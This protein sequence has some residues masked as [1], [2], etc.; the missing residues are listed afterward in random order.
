MIRTSPLAIGLAVL[1][2]GCVNEAADLGQPVPLALT[3]VVRQVVVP[4]GPSRGGRL[5]TAALRRGVD[6]LAA[7]VPGA[8]RAEI[9]ADSPGTA[10]T[11]R[12]SLI[13]LGLD[14]ARITSVASARARRGPEVVLSRTTAIPADCRAAVAPTFGHDPLPSLMNVAHC[15]QANDLAAM[16][17]D[18][19]DLVAPPKLGQADGAYLADGVG[20]WR[21][22]RQLSL[23]GVGPAPSAAVGGGGGPPAPSPGV[24][25]SGNLAPPSVKTS[26]A[27]PAIAP[28]AP[29][30]IP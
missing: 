24:A 5:E 9:V 14:P 4:V 10:E 26:V 16:L 27:T 25:A 21:T 12:R 18:P 11:V 8:V 30:T 13:G 17:V 22:N 29:V 20:S 2:S 7:G 1:L 6:D 19:A 3:T 23:S 15:H 28:S